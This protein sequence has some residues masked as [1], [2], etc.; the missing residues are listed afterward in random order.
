M[1]R[2][3]AQA[4]HRLPILV[5]WMRIAGDVHPFDPGRFG[6]DRDRL[7]SQ[8]NQTGFGLGAPFSEVIVSRIMV[9]IR[10]R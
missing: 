1:F 4:Y 5:G 7:R 10:G 3:L 6:V 2:F 9:S 8:L